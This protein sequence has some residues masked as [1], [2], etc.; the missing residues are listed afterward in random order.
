MNFSIGTLDERAWRATEPGTPNPRRRIEA[1]R[2]LTAAGIR[3]GAL[4]APVLPGISDR[5]GQLAEVVEAVLGAG[6]RILGALPLHLRPG[7]REHYLGWLAGHDP[8]LHARYEKAYRGRAYL[9]AA[10]GQWLTRVVGELSAEYRD[11][12]RF[13]ALGPSSEPG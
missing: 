12:R 11:R 8:V 5:R 13:E 2:R 1:M 9:D 10:Y 3:T 4:I 7:T 6:G